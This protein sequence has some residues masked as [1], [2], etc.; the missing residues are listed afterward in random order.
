[1][2][3]ILLSEQEGGLL[4]NGLLCGRKDSL[5]SA[6]ESSFRLL[7][8][9]PAW[10]N[11]QGNERIA[12]HP[13]TWSKTNYACTDTD[14][15]DGVPEVALAYGERSPSRIDGTAHVCF[16]LPKAVCNSL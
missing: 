2:S 11:Q 3:V 16:A 5:Y 6:K 12:E 8:R 1:M 14:R 13:L 15:G 10:S 4:T 7:K 9:A